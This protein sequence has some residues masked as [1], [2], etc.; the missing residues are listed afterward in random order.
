MCVHRK[1]FRLIASTQVTRLHSELLTIKEFSAHT[2]ACYITVLL[3]K[4]VHGK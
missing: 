1:D 3:L 2:R 4:C